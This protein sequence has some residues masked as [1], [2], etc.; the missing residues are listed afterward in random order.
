MASTTKSARRAGLIDDDGRPNSAPSP[1]AGAPRADEGDS[2][3]KTRR[4]GR[5]P[6]RLTRLASLATLYLVG[7]TD[8]LVDQPNHWEVTVGLV[9][10]SPAE[11]CTVDVTPR[12]LQHF[13]ARPGERF[14]WSNTRL[15]DGQGLQSGWVTADRFGLVTLPQVVVERGGNRI[16]IW[17]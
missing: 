14:R 13:A 16:R 9:D 5:S 7:Q 11:R 2:L 6:A 3:V 1:P 8:D 12:R 15:S 10:R 4:V 17:R